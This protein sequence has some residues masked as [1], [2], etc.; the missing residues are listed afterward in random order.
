MVNN[1]GIGGTENHGMVHEVTEDTWDTVV[2]I[3]VN[4]P[5][6]MGIVGQAV[7]RSKPDKS[8]EVAHIA[9]T[10]LISGILRT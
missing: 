6:V 5:S 8:S 9:N 3:N 7:Y 10:V 1:A 2:A 4:A